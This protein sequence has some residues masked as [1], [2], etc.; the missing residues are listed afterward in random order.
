ML[1]LAQHQDDFLILYQVTKLKTFVRCV[2]V[3]GPS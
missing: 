3:P 1:A 2:I